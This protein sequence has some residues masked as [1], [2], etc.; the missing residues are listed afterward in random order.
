MLYYALLF[1]VVAV[2]AG[3]LGFGVVEGTAAWIA[4]ILAVV[5]IVLFLISLVTG[6]RP[7]VT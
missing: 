2:V 3:I 1:L 7:P 4:Q 6:R 5:F